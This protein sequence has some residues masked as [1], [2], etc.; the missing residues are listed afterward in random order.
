MPIEKKISE[1][2]LSN[3]DYIVIGTGISAF[4][5]VQALNSKNYEIYSRRKRKNNYHSRTR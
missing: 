2:N 1:I 5:F 4:S 3:Y